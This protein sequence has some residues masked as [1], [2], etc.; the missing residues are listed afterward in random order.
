MIE[1]TEWSLLGAVGP[2][3]SCSAGYNCAKP[4]WMT[5]IIHSY[6]LG[7]RITELQMWSLGDVAIEGAERLCYAA[8]GPVILCSAGCNCAKHADVTIFAYQ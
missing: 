5:S 4:V 8:V 2:V 1:G 6:V 7:G 3:V